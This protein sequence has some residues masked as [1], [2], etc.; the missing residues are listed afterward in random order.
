[1]AIYD[2]NRLRVTTRNYKYKRSQRLSDYEKK[3][4]N[5]YSLEAKALYIKHQIE[6]ELTRVDIS[7]LIHF[8]CVFLGNSVQTR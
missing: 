4:G 6:I 1:M 3:E 5:Y 7:P 8:L 2:Y